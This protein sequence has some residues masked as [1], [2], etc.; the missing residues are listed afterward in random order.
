M[1]KTH[2][3]ATA[4]A[5]FVILALAAAPSLLA[6]TFSA[7]ISGIV[8]D[9]SGAVT[10]GA[11]VELTNMDTHDV[12]DYTTTGDGTYKFDNLIPGT[13]QIT[14]D[15]RGFKTFERSNMLLRAETSA[16]VDVS[17]EVGDTQQKVE[18]TGEAVL[19]DTQSANNSVTMDSQLIEALPNNT[20]NP[21]NFVFS[22]AGTT[23]AQGGMTSRSQTFDQLFSMFGLN[24]GRAGDAQIL[25]D[26]APSTAMDWGGL[27]VSPMNDSVQEQQV[28]TNVYDSQYE[29]SGMG[30]VTLITKGGSDSFHGEAYDYLR[31]SALDANLWSNNKYGLPKNQLKRNQFGGNIS[32]PILKRYNLY[33]FGA[34][35]G[36]R[37]PDTENSGLQTVP[38]A[39]E[40]SGDFSQ[41]LNQNGQLRTIYNPFS[42]TQATDPATGSTYY[43]RTPFAGNKIPS[44]LITPQGQAVVNLFPLPNRPSDQPYDSDNY[45]SQGRGSTSNDKFDWRIDWDGNSKNRVFVRMSDR[46]REQQIPACFFCNGADQG[47]NNDDAAFQVVVND[48]FTPSPSWV[49]NAYVGYSRWRETHLPVGVG[50]A[51]AS[52]IGLPVS[53]FQAPVLPTV[54]IDD[55]S[56]LGNGFY[57][58]YVRYSETAQINLSKEFS[59]HSLKFGANYDV[60]LINNNQQGV[61]S[62]YFS[63]YLS[64]CDPTGFASCQ[65]TPGQSSNLSGSGLVETLL[66]I[67]DINST[68]DMDP[69]MSQHAYGG[70]VQDQ[71]RVT[72]RLTLNIGLRYENQ[73][74]ATERYNRLAWFDPTVV[75]PISSQ[76]GY[77]VRGGFEYANSKNRYAWAPDNTNFAPRLG[78]AYRASDRMVVRAGAGIF[79]SPTSAMLSF[80]GGQFLGYGSTTNTFGS[81]DAQGVYPVQT[82]LN[83]FP[84]GL[85]Q[86]TGSS[87]GLN[88]YVGLGASQIWPKGS[89]PVGYS[90]QWSFDIQY[91]LDSHSVF[92]AGYTGVNGRKLMYG[93]PNLNANQLPTQDLALGFNYLNTQVANPFYG[94]ITDP[95]S[96]LSGPTVYQYQLLLPYPEFSNLNWTRSLPGA[97]SS[98]NAL[99]LKYNHAFTNGLSAIVTYRWSKALDDGSED[100][101]GWAVGNMWRD[102][103]NTKL[104]Y[105]VSEH[106]QPHSFAVAA[107]YDL[108]YGVGKRWGATA[109]WLV[110]QVLGNWQLSSN[111]RVAS[112]L[113]LFGISDGNYTP[114]TYFYG[115]PGNGNG[116][117]PDI[118]GNP[119]PAHQTPDNWI[120][121]NA[122]VSTYNQ[123]RY[124]DTP[125]RMPYLREEWTKNVD[126][127][128]AK[129][130]GPERF[131]VQFRGEFLNAFNTPIFGGNY[132]INLA[133]TNGGP[134]GQWTGTRNDPRNIQFSLKASF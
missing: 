68:T 17:L 24:G 20:R 86:Q 97:T 124:G 28:M 106:D 93:N 27:M 48:T 25:I 65:A 66:G 74:P 69:A 11:K 15:A 115:F 63:N 4:M 67:G 58:N 8:R 23:E 49:I 70:Y 31:N 96:G 83:P 9:P 102:S 84:S 2:R 56:G 111:V 30:V 132:N 55:Y 61:G 42:T 94:V 5:C 126:L 52:T 76:V 26:G 105:G 79:Y 6:Q 50:K 14:V 98:Y 77:T 44:N 81:V 29:R 45:Y 123:P 51:D 82:M 64:A 107:V 38:T 112:G 119:V 33:F 108:P 75:N 13:Y 129:S 114:L 87:Q 103:Y 85:N 34:Y 121:P 120:N 117:I 134:F 110:R 62:V 10:S 16:T 46:V 35:E 21:L 90:E 41:T 92:E 73:R 12:R 7:S 53:D 57:A 133:L 40:R 104:D 72:P 127:S 43:T 47:N 37:Q 116:E 18:V 19:V 95:S 36:L 101:I 125:N 109:P 91:Q 128:V 78:I 59:K 32:G 80:D 100:L 71:W 88:T 54:S 99:D 60:F 131:R 118:I 113:P 122:F 3:I 89:H 39:L 130:F 22:L 1:K